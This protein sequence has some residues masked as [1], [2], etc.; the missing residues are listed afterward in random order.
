[1]TNKAVYNIPYLKEEVSIILVCSLQSDIRDF[2]KTYSHQNS[3]KPHPHDK[4]K[5]SWYVTF[6]N[7]LYFLEQFQVHSKKE[8]E[9]LCIHTHSL[10]DY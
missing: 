6:F 2:L 8:Q 3:F 10:P 5:T 1:M 4:L 9:E 7:Q